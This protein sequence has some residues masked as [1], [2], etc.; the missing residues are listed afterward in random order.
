LL[1]RLLLSKES[2]S[3]TIG[4]ELELENIPLLGTDHSRAPVAAL[5]IDENKVPG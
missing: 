5:S 3:A 2:V 4:K 1:T